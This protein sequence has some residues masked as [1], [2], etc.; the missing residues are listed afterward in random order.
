MG[1]ASLPV[2]TC[3]IFST[4]TIATQACVVSDS[5][6]VCVVIA[7]CVG[8][9]VWVPQVSLNGLNGLL[10]TGCVRIKQHFASDGSLG[11]V[12]A[13]GC[14]GMCGVCV[15]VCSVWVCGCVGV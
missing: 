3:V 7:V 4:H 9:R 12:C 10:S 11:S 8:A 5:L 1:S 2:R 14:V 6:S 15:C 13:C